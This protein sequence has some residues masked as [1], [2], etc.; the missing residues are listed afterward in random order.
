MR[1]QI[2]LTE[3][4][5]HRIVKS[6]IKE[7]IGDYYQTPEQRIDD[8]RREHTKME[9]LKG[10]MD[11]I[12]HSFA[13]TFG[14]EMSDKD[15][16][17]AL[18]TL[19]LTPQIKDEQNQMKNKYG[20]GFERRNYGYYRGE[21]E[22]RDDTPEEIAKNQQNKIQMIKT[23]VLN[24]L[25]RYGNKDKEFS[26]YEDAV[27]EY[28]ESGNKEANVRRYLAGSNGFHG[29]VL[30]YFCTDSQGRP[31]FCPDER[32]SRMHSVMDVCTNDELYKYCPHNREEYERMK[33]KK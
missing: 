23:Q 1:K 11:D 15:F 7:A 16:K 25:I 22:V 5:L 14:Y 31:F 32:R 18:Y 21:D 9:W 10:K 12:R 30:F 3:S 29:G 26:L 27:S 19:H 2:R 17:N 28:M 33:S 20:K 8:K 6:V 4:D 13:S 24:P